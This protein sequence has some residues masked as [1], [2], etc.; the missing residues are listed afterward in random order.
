LGFSIPSASS[1]PAPLSA[2]QLWELCGAATRELAWGLRSVSREIHAWRCAARAIPDAP[3]REDALASLAHKRTHA[4]GA[5][6]FSI[7]PRHRDGPLLRVLVAYETILDFLDN[8]NERHPT[9]ANGRQLHLALVDALDV[10]SG[11]RDYYRHH[12]VRDDR[13]YLRALVRTCRTG[14]ATLPGYGHVRPL[15]RRETIRALVLGINHDPIPAARD[16]ELARWAARECAE[17]RDAAAW[18]ELSSAAS[19]SLTIHALLALAAE[20]LTAA[21]CA[22]RDLRAGETR[23]LCAAYFPWISATS[24]MLDSYV[25]RDRDLR[26][27]GHSYIAHY[28]SPEAAIRRVGELV[29]HS[30]SGAR[31]L[32][33]GHRHAVIAACMVAMYLSADA[34][35]APL[36]RANT[37]RLAAAGGSL[38]LALLPVLRL[39]RTLYAL[40]SA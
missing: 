6:L 23:A 26:S 35:R 31:A 40:R 18:F 34:T 8:V 1:N 38:P 39:W 25:D 33:R 13:S 17:H 32:R 16:A 28:P 36:A 37:R 9:R 20:P 4:D 27:G 3:L 21:P 12:P 24:T 11:A 5:A 10:R 15:L 29:T 7:L 2:R 30:L 19:A 14:S 22:E